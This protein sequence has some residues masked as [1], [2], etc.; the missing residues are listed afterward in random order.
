GQSLINMP[1]LAAGTFAITLADGC[2]VD[3]AHR[4]V[5]GTGANG[6]S[7]IVIF[8]PTGLTTTIADTS[9]FHIDLPWG[10]TWDS[11]NSQLIVA[12]N[13]SW[14]PGVSFYTTGGAFQKTDPHNYFANSQNPYMVP[15]NG[16]GLFAVAYTTAVSSDQVQIYTNAAGAGAPTP[17]FG[18][19]PFNATSDAGC[20]SYPYGSNAVVSGMTWLSNTRLLVALTSFNSGATPQVGSVGGQAVGM[21]LYIFDTA[22]SQTPALWDD[23]TCTAVA[24]YPAQKAFQAFSFKPFATAFKP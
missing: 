19:I 4:G 1:S 20:T 18:P 2:E 5:C 15:A 21:G 23:Q 8:G 12:N 10:L 17:V 16:A 3:A 24:A 6:T 7:E 11:T 14:H 22:T 13:S 9:T